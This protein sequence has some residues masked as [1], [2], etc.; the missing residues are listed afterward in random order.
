MAGFQKNLDD[1]NLVV[2]YMPIL[3]DKN[4]GKRHVGPTPLFGH[5]EAARLPMPPRRMQRA[6]PTVTAAAGAPRLD[7]SRNGATV[8]WRRQE[9]RRCG[10]GGPCGVGARWQRAE[11]EPEKEEGRSG[12]EAAAQGAVAVGG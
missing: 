12:G 5:G 2:W 4:S 3:G 7:L 9:G 10:G 8:Q 11:K 6:S 1:K